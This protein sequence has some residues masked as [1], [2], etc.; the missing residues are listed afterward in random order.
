MIL[1]FLFPAMLILLAIAGPEEAK[2]LA[3]EKSSA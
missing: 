1:L 3:A 2:N